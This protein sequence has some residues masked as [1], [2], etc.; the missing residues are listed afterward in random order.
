MPEQEK[1][2][3]VED[4]L[5]MRE[6]LYTILAKHEYN[7]LTAPN[8]EEAIKLFEKERPGLAIID[9]MMPPGLN[10]LETFVQL[11]RIDPHVEGII[12][13]GVYTEDMESQARKLGFSDV[14]RKGIG[15]E[16][17]LK[18]VNYVLEKRRAKG[19]QPPKKP[20]GKILVVDDE[21][22]I[23]FMLEKFFTRYGYQVVTA[24]S[25]EE[26]LKIVSE[27]INSPDYRT[28]SFLV[29]LDIR[30]PGMDGLITLD[31]IKA[32]DKSSRGGSASGGKIGVVMI[33]GI[34][35]EKL[36][37]EAME[38]GAYDFIMKP[39]N[40]EYMEMVVMT[41]ILLAD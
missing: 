36:T 10:G 28:T 11:R 41:K 16:L 21:P 1:V 18:S 25:G 17:F 33:S 12:L 8:G 13:T 9:L 3:I 29:L 37:R 19:I 40:M 34:N 2:L 20:K 7:V 23:R 31:K 35:D 32:L 38:L 30:M 24:G 39:F 27:Q 15:V 6:L 22:E 26:A 5:A 4:E 14:L